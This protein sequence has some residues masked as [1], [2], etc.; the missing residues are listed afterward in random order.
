ME[1]TINTVKIDTELDEFKV[2]LLG[3]DSIEE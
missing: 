1:K 3:L 2:K